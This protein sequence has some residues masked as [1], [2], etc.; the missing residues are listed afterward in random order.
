MAAVSRDGSI[1]GRA[2]RSTPKNVSVDEMLFMIRDAADECGA[3]TEGLAAVGAAVPATVNYEHGVMLKAPNLPRLDGFAMRTALG[4][5]FG[6]PVVLENDANAAA[7]GENWLG[8]SK[9]MRD[10]ILVTLG[11]GVGGGIIIGG[12]VLRGAD[13][14]AGEIGHICLEPQG[15][16]CGCGSRGCVEQ[17]ASASALVRMAHELIGRYPASPLASRDGF[18]SIDVFEAGSAGD[19]LALETFRRMGSC[20]GIALADLINIFNP[21]AIVIG[22]G[23]AAA[24]DL[25]I[26]HVRAEIGVRAFSEPAERALLLK[27]SLGDDG[28]ILGSAKLAFDRIGSGF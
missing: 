1:L 4:E 18:S 12:N 23:A 8:A 24:W 3:D 11:T 15:V 16:D 9:G 10:S 14:T 17:Y 27:S 28:G 26:E 5:L 6:V 22:G 21:E 7:V 2:R 19:P 25:F 13:G 20:L